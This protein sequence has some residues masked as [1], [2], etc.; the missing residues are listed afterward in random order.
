MISCTYVV[1]SRGKFRG[2]VPNELKHSGD[3]WPKR[4]PFMM[5]RSVWKGAAEINQEPPKGGHGDGKSNTH[6]HTHKQG[7]TVAEGHDNYK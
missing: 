5:S 7:G 6:T 2:Q 1:G 4:R 3:K